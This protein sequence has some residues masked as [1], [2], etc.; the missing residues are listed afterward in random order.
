MFSIKKLI[1][2]SCP[3]SKCVLT[4]VK[5]RHFAIINFFDENIGGT[6]DFI[7]LFNPI[8]EVGS[9]PKVDLSPP[10]ARLIRKFLEFRLFAQ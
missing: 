4:L 1:I 10:I 6:I 2:F 7:A 5:T 8:L 9:A 3:N